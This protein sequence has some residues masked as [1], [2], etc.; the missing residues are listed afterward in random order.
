MISQPKTEVAE[1]L[2]Q[3]EAADQADLP[4]EQRFQLRQKPLPEDSDSIMVRMSV[5]CDKPNQ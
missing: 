3:A 1:L 4:D 5:C 2:H